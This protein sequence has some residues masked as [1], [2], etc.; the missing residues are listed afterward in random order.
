MAEMNDLLEET[1]GQCSALSDELDTT[2]AGIDAMTGKATELCDGALKVG[3]QIRSR[4]QALASR[5]DAAESALENARADAVTDLDALA[6]Q[7]AAVRTDV[8]D[9]LT[10]VQ[11]GLTELEQQQTQLDES[12]QEG[13]QALG[14]GFTDLGGH[15]AEAQEAIGNELQE[16]GQKIAAFGEAVNTAR[17]DLA[18]KQQAWSE[19][20]DTF[21]RTAQEKAR[22]WAGA[23]QGV[24]ADQTTAMVDLAN[25]MLEK[26][27][28]TMEAMKQ[29]FETEAALQVAAAVQPLQ[30]A[31]ERL[32]AA[33][34]QQSGQLTARSEESLQRV[35]ALLPALEEIRNVFQQSGRLG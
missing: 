5:L 20:L 7:A 26:H 31:L 32:G 27:N 33:A 18:E 35:R 28:D 21:E 25:R 2:V 34:A 29:Q 30:D 14:T 8:G 16:A 12:V 4:L 19:A 13:L 17:A 23:L 3:G 1:E 6:E 10:K 9:L 24:L 15:V 11:D 22:D